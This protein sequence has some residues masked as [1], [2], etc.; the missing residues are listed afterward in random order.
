[1]RAAASFVRAAR[2]ARAVLAACAA[3][4]AVLALLGCGLPA[5]TLPASPAHVSTFDPPTTEAMLRAG[6]EE[7]DAQRVP[8]LLVH[9]ETKRGASL[10]AALGTRDLRRRDAASLDDCVR[11]GSVVKMLTAIVTVRLAE[12]GVVALDEPVSRW[13]PDFPRARDM[14]LTQLLSHRAGVPEVISMRSLM[15]ATLFPGHV[16]SRET[17]LAD[18]ATADRTREPGAEFHYS[19]GNT[20][21]AGAALENASKR[22]FRALLGEHVLSRA[23]TSRTWLLPTDPAPSTLLVGYDRGLVPLG[24]DV[25]PDDTSWA[26]LAWTSGALASTA[27]DL[28]AIVRGVRDA[29]LVSPKGREN[30][31]PRWPATGEHGER[32]VGVGLFRFNIGGRTFIGHAGLFIGSQAVAVWDEL[33]GT[34][35]VVIGNRSPFD[36][37]RVVARLGD[38]ARRAG[39]P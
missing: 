2:A 35:Y 30:M 9:V 25:L 26:S 29:T 13:L 38:I 39:P 21:V 36:V 10:S 28:A 8:A 7:L 11:V 20:I 6:A 3:C 17:L 18:L 12:E 34:I 33:D 16:F 14:T 5:Y 19:N 1:M 22:P 27:T 23:Q 15:K 32:A 37:N 31:L 4:V 24:H